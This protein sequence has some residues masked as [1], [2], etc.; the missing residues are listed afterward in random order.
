MTEELM[1]PKRPAQ[2]TAQGFAASE[3]S[4]SYPGGTAVLLTFTPV[5]E[6]GMVL[7]PAAAGLGIAATVLSR[8]QPR[9]CC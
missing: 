5:P 1:L 9:L 8:P 4:V 7:G 3:W 6:P 2:L